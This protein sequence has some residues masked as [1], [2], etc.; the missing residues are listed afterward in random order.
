[1]TRA[2]LLTYAASLFAALAE[3]AQ[4]PLEDTAAGLKYQ[5]DGVQAATAADSDNADAQQALIEYHTLRKMRIAL[6]ARSDVNSTGIRKGR[7]QIF[8]QVDS[9]IKDASERSAAAGY[10]VAS[11]GDYGHT[12]L[13]LDYLEP[14]DTAL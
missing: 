8:E 10:A 9:L 13:T 14:E 11:A 5:L 12:A 4:I 6:A 1:M 2:D 7:S 3:E